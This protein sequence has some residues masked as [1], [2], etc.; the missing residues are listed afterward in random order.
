MAYEREHRLDDRALESPADE[1]DCPEV[2]TFVPGKQTRAEQLDRIEAFRSPKAVGLSANPGRHPFSAPKLAFRDFRALALRDVLSRLDHRPALRDATLAAADPNVARRVAARTVAADRTR[3]PRNGE[4]MWRAAERR[5]VTLYRRALATGNVAL[6]TPAVTAALQAIGCGVPLD[7]RVRAKM[8]RILGVRL[9][10][11]RLHTGSVAMDAANAANAEAFTVGEDIFLPAYNP[12]SIDCQRLLLHELVHCCQWWQGR[13]AATGHGV[14]VSQ[15]GDA[16][17]REAETVVSRAF[18]HQRGERA[19][20]IHRL[21]PGAERAPQNVAAITRETS[22]PARSVVEDGRGSADLSPFVSRQ[23]TGTIAPLIPRHAAF[24]SQQWKGES[25]LPAAALHPLTSSGSSPLRIMR[26]A[27]SGH[28]VSAGHHTADASESDILQSLADLQRSVNLTRAQWQEVGGEYVQFVA[29]N[30]ELICGVIAC[31]FTV[32]WA[33]KKLAASKNFRAAAIG[34]TFLLVFDLVALGLSLNDMQA[35][36]ETAWNLAWSAKGDERKIYNAG[37]E[38]ARMA[39]SLVLACVAAGASLRNLLNALKLFRAARAARTGST[40]R[41]FADGPRAGD[42][43]MTW[44]EERQI[45]ESDRAGSTTTAPA[46][47]PATQSGSLTAAPTASAQ[48][49]LQPAYVALGNA[50]GSEATS[51]DK[52]PP[53]GLPKPDAPG[54]RGSRTPRNPHAVIRYPNGEVARVNA[55][56]ELNSSPA[57]RN[58]G[59]GLPGYTDVTIHGDPLSVDAMRRSPVGGHSAAEAR[60]AAVESARADHSLPTIKGRSI[61]N[62]SG[63]EEWTPTHLASV[64]TRIGVVGPI[65]LISCNT[66][67][68]GDGF[69]ARLAWEL[70]TVVLANPE[71]VHIDHTSGVATHSGWFRFEP[72]E[73]KGV[74]RTLSLETW[75][76]RRQFARFARFVDPLQAAPHRIVLD[77]Q[78]ETAV[79]ARSY[80]EDMRAISNMVG[81]DLGLFVETRGRHHLILQRAPRTGAPLISPPGTRELYRVTVG[82]AVPKVSDAVDHKIKQYLKA[83]ESGRRG[84]VRSAASSNQPP[85]M[86]SWGDVNAPASELQYLFKHY[87]ER[88]EIERQSTRAELV[89]N[90]R[91]LLLEVGL[92]ESTWTVISKVSDEKLRSLVEAEHFLP[93]IASLNRKLHSIVEWLAYAYASDRITVADYHYHLKQAAQVAYLPV[94]TLLSAEPRIDGS[95]LLFEARRGSKTTW[96]SVPLGPQGNESAGQLPNSSNRIRVRIFD[97]SRRIWIEAQEADAKAMPRSRDQEPDSPAPARERLG[98]TSRSAAS[99]PDRFHRAKRGLDQCFLNYYVNP[100]PAGLEQLLTSVGTIVTTEAGVPEATWQGF[101]LLNPYKLATALQTKRFLEVASSNKPQVIE[102][103]KQLTKLYS[104]GDLSLLMYE[105]SL[106]RI[107]A[108]LAL[109]EATGL[110]PFGRG[111]RRTLRFRATVDGQSAFVKAPERLEDDQV[112]DSD[113]RA[114]SSMTPRSGPNWGPV[115]WFLLVRYFD[116]KYGLWREAVAMEQFPN[117]V[118]IGTLYTLMRINE[119]LPF[120]ITPAHVQAVESYQARLRQ[121]HVEPWDAHAWNN[122]LLPFNSGDNRLFV[123]VDTIVAPTAGFSPSDHRDDIVSMTKQ[124][125]MYSEQQPAYDEPGPPVRE[126]APINSPPAMAGASP[127]LDNQ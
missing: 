68:Y 65:R 80:A 122:L 10:R 31:F 108:I 115:R 57:L 85:A 118:S 87:F 29:D 99:A 125:M 77:H 36:A 95:T 51:P 119:K 90:V 98:K 43:E 74:R 107:E 79:H 50:K 34:Q 8:E 3:K 82:E 4:G 66:G 64:L 112:I 81:A 120:A 38:W 109:H 7:P 33:S 111:S 20:A 114:L 106:G 27:K 9:D 86:R 89:S 42:I 126:E 48:A 24:R 101:R 30:W 60:R 37:V 44:N 72:V 104:S 40:T 16:L 88:S 113:W 19:D 76:D 52:E 41:S 100:S 69:A 127:K 6:E 54:P 59:N 58:V 61:R 73:G 49:E 105:Y 15:P 22:P 11:V 94:A 121:D 116:T 56:G 17:E 83:M 92:S 62:D 123:P 2:D 75:Q 110:V 117:G 91:Q 13:I 5:A 97:L 84:P 55:L 14:A 53:A 26:Q 67:A 78:A 18:H 124:L 71:V 28:E 46:P 47:V 21:Q 102:Q 35:H 70:K 32:E 23:R 1:L 45:F 63:I 12:E 39:V 93:A 96:V 25:G 103:L